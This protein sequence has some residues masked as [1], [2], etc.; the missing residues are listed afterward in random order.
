LT[1]QKTAVSREVRRQELAETSFGTQGGQMMT[2]RNG[3]EL[4]D[5]ANI[6]ANSGFMI[7]DFYRGNTGACAALIMICSSYGFNP[8]QVSWKTYKASKSDDAPI[9]FE[10]QLVNAMVNMSAPIKGRLQYEFK[11]EG[12]ARRCT[13]WGETRDGTI[14]SY[15]TPEIGKI[16]VKNSPLWTSD[17]D[18]QL[19]YFAARSWC[20]RH[21]P[22]MLLGVYSRDE[23]PEEPRD[24]TPKPKF[25]D[26]LQGRHDL[27]AEEPEE[28]PADAVS[29]PVD[30]TEEDAERMA[31]E[32][33]RATDLQA[34]QE[35]PL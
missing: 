8:F 7:R 6:M 22:E 4:M 17:P 26:R 15:E 33:R 23:L 25:M 5:M 29:I 16:K 13:V 30:F 2:P 11:G 27:E 3:R 28:T 24:V 32:V 10:A 20:R 21:F 34:E 18:Q 19:G 35:E 9:S 1:E 31:A 14:L 12:T